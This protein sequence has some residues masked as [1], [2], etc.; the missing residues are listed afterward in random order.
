MFP[1]YVHLWWCWKWPISNRLGIS[2]WWDLVCSPPLAASPN[3]TIYQL[4]LWNMRSTPVL[5]L[6]A[7]SQPLPREH[8]LHPFED[9]YLLCSPSR[10]QWYAAMS[11]SSCCLL[12]SK[13]SRSLCCCSV[14]T[15]ISPISASSLEMTEPRFCSS[16]SC[17]CLASYKE[18]SRPLFCKGKTADN[19]SVNSHMLHRDFCSGLASISIDYIFWEFLSLGTSVLGIT[20]T[21]VEVLSQGADILHIV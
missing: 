5:L 8:V 17:Q 16:M 20:I 1:N 13:F 14:S 3:L 12:V 18:F 9:K 7:T 11:F 15:L 2:V 19:K 4:A 6:P 10:R 21:K